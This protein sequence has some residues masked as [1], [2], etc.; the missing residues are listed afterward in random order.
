[1]HIV[2]TYVKRFCSLQLWSE[3]WRERSTRRAQN[4]RAPSP[5]CVY[6][7]RTVVWPR[8][9]FPKNQWSQNISI[10]PVA[11]KPAPVKS[12]RRHRGMRVGVTQG[13]ASPSRPRAWQRKL[14]KCSPAV[15]REIS[16]NQH[17]FY[18]REHGWGPETCL[19]WRRTASSVESPKVF[20]RWTLGMIFF[21]TAFG[22]HFWGLLF[23]V[24]FLVHPHHP[25]H[26]AC[27]A[28]LEPVFLMSVQNQKAR[29]L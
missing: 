20:K 16:L 1:M 25:P 8:A 23:A 2:W 9:S 22:S 11:D 21:L 15:L 10:Y 5:L 19:L 3:R 6:R 12:Q 4:P 17:A 24:E 28:R 27:R 18:S 13:A 7:C 29:M 14:A 26:R